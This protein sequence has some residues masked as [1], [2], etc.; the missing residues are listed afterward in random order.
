MSENNDYEIVDFED[1]L[2][3]SYLIWSLKSFLIPYDNGL[4]QDK[5]KLLLNLASY[6]QYQNNG[7][8]IQE[9]NKLN[10]DH[11]SIFFQIFL[12]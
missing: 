11:I 4:Y 7:I 8:Y 1:E 3:Y 12:L 2:F 6:K 10:Y 9:K 5:N